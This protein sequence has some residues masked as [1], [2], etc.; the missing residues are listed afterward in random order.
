MNGYSL[1]IHDSLG[2]FPLFQGMSKRELTEI[3]GQTRFDFSRHGAGSTIA[4][5][6]SPCE[7]LLFLLNGTITLCR[8]SDDYSCIVEE[9]LPAPSLFFVPHLFGLQRRHGGTYIARDQCET[10][11]IAKEEVLHLIDRYDIFRINLLNFLSTRVQRLSHR[12]FRPYPHNLRE[13]ICRYLSDRCVHPGG[14]KDFRV[15]MEQIAM[16][17]GESRLNVSHELH[18]MERDGLLALGRSLVHVNAMEKMF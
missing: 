12:P 1:A 3:V 8:H 16:E 14:E 2:R 5:E 7:S 11:A 17:I 9:H 15:K 6:G 18:A 10:L 13:K 4:T